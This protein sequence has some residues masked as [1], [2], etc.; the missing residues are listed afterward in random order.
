MKKD[1]GREYGLSRSDTPN[2]SSFFVLLL[3]AKS[4]QRLERLA[5]ARSTVAIDMLLVLRWLDRVSECFLSIPSRGE[6]EALLLSHVRLATTAKRDHSTP[7]KDALLKYQRFE[8]AVRVVTSSAV[9]SVALC[10]K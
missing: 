1:L 5:T 8:I 9:A 7:L 6:S 10:D 4:S 3:R 2:F